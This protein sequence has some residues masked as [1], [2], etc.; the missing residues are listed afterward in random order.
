LPPSSD[1]GHVPVLPDETVEALSLK[2]GVTVLDCTL[3]RGGHASMILPLMTGGHYIGVDVDPSNLAFARERIEPVA[4]AHDVELTTFHTN[5]RAVPVVLDQMG[6]AGT[7]DQLLA[8]IGFASNQVDDPDRGMQFKQD[9]PLDMRM[10]QTSDGPTAKDIVNQMPET[11]LADLIFE[12]GEDR[13]S[14]RIAKRIV[15]HRTTS[16]PIETT[17]QL[18]EIVR[19]AYGAAAK[20]NPRSNPRS[21]PKIN[22]AT[23]TFMALR[24]AVNDEL[25]A[26][27]DL[28]N[29][30]PDLLAPDGRAAIIS[31]HSLEDRRV[32]QR[33]LKLQ[34]EDLGIRI[35]RKPIIATDQEILKNPRSR[36]AKMRVWQK[37]GA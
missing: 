21:A 32:K 25:G 7:V 15:D 34:Q 30:V 3:G 12:L 37:A 24:I 5:F 29:A 6:V 19:L 35:T 23:R 22:P 13:L 20:R 31:F 33:F 8:D 17:G 28:L 11:A 36:S 26:L 9:G 4:Q 18:S 2:P 1:P 10:D 16:G 27:D 14:R